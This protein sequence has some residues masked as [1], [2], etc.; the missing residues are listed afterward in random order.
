MAEIKI[1]GDTNAETAVSEGLSTG[2]QNMR[3]ELGGVV[4]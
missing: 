2:G 4:A 1:V 3:P